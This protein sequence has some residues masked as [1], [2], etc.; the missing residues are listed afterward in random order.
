VG[1][2][3][4]KKKNA[5]PH[6]DVEGCHNGSGAIKWVGVLDGND[7][8]GKS[9]KFFHD[10]V[11]PP[12]TSIGIHTHTDDQEYYYIVSGSGIM[13]LDGEDHDVTAGDITVVLPGGTHG[14]RNCSD[15][16]LRII[17]VSVSVEAD[18][19]IRSWPDM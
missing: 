1:T 5:M 19:G 6:K 13:H 7:P 8:G 15:E 11:L 3:F 2:T 9:M 14:L 12:N 17:V 4:L 18:K 16:D 10:D